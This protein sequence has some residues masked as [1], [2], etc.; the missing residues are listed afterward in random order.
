M[1][2]REH[3]RQ[4]GK[5]AREA[6][7]ALARAST[8][9]KNRA[10]AAM[11]EQI[12]AHSEKILEANRKDVAQAKAAHDA[13]FV[14]RLTLTHKLVEQMAQGVEAVA[15]LEDPVRKI[16]DRVT[17]PTGIEVARMRVPLGVIA[18]VYE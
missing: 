17:R 5:Q 7:R 8:A 14:D 16:S 15:R 9:D 6:S 2:V 1:D 10:L 4:L 3:V 11:A 13:A 18:I 12:R